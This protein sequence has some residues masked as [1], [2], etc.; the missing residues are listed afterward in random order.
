MIIGEHLKENDEEDNPEKNKQLTNVIV[1]M[2][3]FKFFEGMFK[4]I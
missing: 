2:F 1:I 3:I 4:V